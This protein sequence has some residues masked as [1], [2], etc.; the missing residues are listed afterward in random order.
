M[1][2]YDRISVSEVIDIN[3]TSASKDCIIW[4]YGYFLDKGFTFQIIVTVCN[5]CHDVITRC[6]LIL[7]VLLV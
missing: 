2:N 1:L 3:N 4:Y 5:G 7:T 6:L